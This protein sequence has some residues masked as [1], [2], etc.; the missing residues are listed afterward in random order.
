MEKITKLLSNR[1]V[2]TNI[3]TTSFEVILTKEELSYLKGRK[4][5]GK[6]FSL[7][8]GRYRFLHPYKPLL[9]IGNNPMNYQIHVEIENHNFTN[10]KNIDTSKELLEIKLQLEKVQTLLNKFLAKDRTE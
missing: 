8:Y 3:L 5:K 10:K 1:K 6:F 2:K 9:Q 7:P 4:Y